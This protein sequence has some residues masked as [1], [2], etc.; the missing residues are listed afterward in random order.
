MVTFCIICSF[1]SVN[2]T[3]TA[4][5]KE[6]SLVKERWGDEPEPSKWKERGRNAWWRAQQVQRRGVGQALGMFQDPHRNSSG[7]V[8]DGL[9]RAVEGR[10]EDRGL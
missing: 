2:L 1:F 6:S 4:L 8:R 3:N 10:G 7:K 5:K 9:E